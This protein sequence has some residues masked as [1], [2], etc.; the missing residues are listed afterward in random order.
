MS[1]DNEVTARWV[2]A[3][4]TATGNEKAD[5]FAKAAASQSAPRE[6]IPDEHRWETSLP[7]MSTEAR[8]RPAAERVTSRVS[9]QPPGR[10]GAPTKAT[11]LSA[12]GGC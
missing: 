12:R 1:R 10:E 9:V 11:P 6:E 2:P 8:S 4:S 7:H 5:D 3:H